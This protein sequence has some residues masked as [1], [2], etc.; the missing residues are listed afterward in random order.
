MHDD[1]NVSTCG[2]A[3]D[4]EEQQAGAEQGNIIY[5]QDSVPLTAEYV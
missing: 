3:I 5:M 1:R 4:D 2:G